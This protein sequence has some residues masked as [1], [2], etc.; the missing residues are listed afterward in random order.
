MSSQLEEVLRLESLDVSYN[1]RELLT[2]IAISINKLYDVQKPYDWREIY[3][4]SV[5]IA[6]TYER[7]VF[8]YT[9]HQLVVMPVPARIEIILDSDSAPYILEEGESLNIT[10]LAKIMAISNTAN[11]TIT[12]EVRIY[13]FGRK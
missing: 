3:K 12:E 10:T 4:H 11:P 9:V 1:Q 2:N 5:L 7:Y 8:D 13:V 6:H